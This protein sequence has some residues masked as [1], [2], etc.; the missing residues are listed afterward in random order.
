M[1][2]VINGDDYGFTDGITE[3][4]IFCHLNG[5]LSS[6]TVLVNS[7][8]IEKSVEKAKKC[9]DLGF[10]IHFN[11]TLGKPLTS[12]KTICD[13]NGNFYNKKD[14]TL[15]NLDKD[16]IYNEWKAQIER[17][18]ELFKRKPTHIDS[19]HSVHDN[20]YTYQIT[21][22]L[23]KEYNLT[24]RRHGKFK[25]VTGF[26]GEDATVENLI[27]LFE[28]NKNEEFIEVM[29]HPGYSDCKLRDIS[30]YNNYRLKELVTLCDDRLKE[31]IKENNIELVTY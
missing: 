27:N 11:L 7:D 28:K 12:G 30:S 26:F 4:I 24:C 23:C 22:K 14:L 5:I 15:E 31:Y 16:E 19:H 13:E 17:F 20:L 18:I 29:V 6:T 10:G 21:E 9:P 25:Y 3:G 8:D 1:K 2:V